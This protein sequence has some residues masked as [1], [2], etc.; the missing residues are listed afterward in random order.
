MTSY[1]Y[2][3]WDPP[4]LDAPTPEEIT[5]EALFSVAGEWPTDAE[6]AEALAEDSAVSQRGL[7]FPTAKAG[8]PPAYVVGLSTRFGEDGVLIDRLGEEVLSKFPSLHGVWDVRLSL[9]ARVK[10]V[11]HEER[12]FYGKEGLALEAAAERAVHNAM[13]DLLLDVYLRILGKMTKP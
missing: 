2:Q 10:E 3:S 11:I 9:S 8:D 4:A 7:S 1:T 12:V 5:R 13:G 6:V